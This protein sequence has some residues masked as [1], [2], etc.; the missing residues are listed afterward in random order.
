[1]ATT[2]HSR[3]YTHS[4]VNKAW[5]MKVAMAK[6]A[7]YYARQGRIDSGLHTQKNKN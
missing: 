6:F 7:S 4:Y 2:L 3:D 1:M 5:V